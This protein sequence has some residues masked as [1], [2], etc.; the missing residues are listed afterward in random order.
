[1]EF[2]FRNCK[3][4]DEAKTLYKELCKIWHPDLNQKDTTAEFQA[5]QNEFHAFKPETE[6]FEGEFE[7]WNSEEYAF[8]IDQLLNIENITVTVCGSWIW[9]SGSTKEQKDKIKT[10]ETGETMKRGWSPKKLQWYFSPSGY[11]KRSKKVLSF[12]RIRELYGSEDVKRQARK[13]IY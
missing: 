13:T 7:Q 1:M 9:I 4:L 5:M 12:D 11:R 6:K 3:T 10:V 2:N 8:I